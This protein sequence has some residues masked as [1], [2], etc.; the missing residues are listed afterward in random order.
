MTAYYNE[1]D[2]YVAQWLRN[3]ID[4]GHI[5]PGDVDE[6][7]IIDVRADELRGYT[8]CHFFAGIGGWSLALR[9]A[10]WPDDRPVWTGSCPCQDFSIVGLR[11]GFAG[12]RD[13]WPGWRG[14][15]AECRPDRIF[16]EQVD[17]APQ[18]LDRA[19]GDLEALRY[20]V[21]AVVLPAFAAGYR[22]ERM[23]LYFVA[24]ADEARWANAQ[25][26]AAAAPCPEV[27]DAACLVGGD[28]CGEIR[29]P[30]LPDESWIVDGDTAAG[31]AVSAIGNAIVPQLAAQFIL[32]AEG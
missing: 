16:G 26:I 31:R 9:L 32:A 20:A 10:G 5:A 13:L 15:I 4:A 27:R 8:Q 3:L 29:W 22:H 21:G 6:R 12:D 28:A 7:S 19:A 2:P 1:H 11:K 18:W 14:L 24:D 17:L 25:R 30:P 23:R